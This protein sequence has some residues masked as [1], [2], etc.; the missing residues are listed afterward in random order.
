[1]K[2]FE[3]IFLKYPELYK[4][5][6]VFDKYQQKIVGTGTL[7][8]MLK[9]QISHPKVSGYISDIFNLRVAYLTISLSIQI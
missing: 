3:E 1:M 4:V 9:F 7:C 8:I 5:I 2:N 6:V